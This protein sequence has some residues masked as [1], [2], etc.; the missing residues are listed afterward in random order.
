MSSTTHPISPA[1][2]AQALESLPS[3]SLYA[4][5]QELQ[6]SLEHLARSN[7]EL[8]AYSDSVS[9]D[10]DC[11]EA[12]RENEEVMGRMRERIALVREEVERRGG[13]WHEADRENGVAGGEAVLNGDG[14]QEGDVGEERALP[15]AASGTRQAAEQEPPP[16]STQAPG[17]SLTDEELRRRLT[18]QMR[19]DSGEEDGLHL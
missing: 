10:S 16:P 6:N 3:S 2:F 5:T 14:G 4:K 15:P 1:A 19:D 13:R 9:G 11:L 17:G 8:Q 12:V 7:A 18:E